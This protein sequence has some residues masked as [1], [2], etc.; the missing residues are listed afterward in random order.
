MHREGNVR[1]VATA[2]RHVLSLGMWI[3]ATKRAKYAAFF[4]STATI[5]WDTRETNKKFYSLP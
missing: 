5:C 4:A 1:Y 3:I 2:I